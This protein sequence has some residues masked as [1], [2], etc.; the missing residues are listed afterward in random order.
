MSGARR[1]KRL[2]SRGREVIKPMKNAIF[3]QACRE[4]LASGVMLVAVTALAACSPATSVRG[5]SA[6]AA[7]EPQ[8]A[9]PAPESS[10]GGGHGRVPTHGRSADETRE[11]SGFGRALDHIK[12][13][14]WA[15]ARAAFE[16]LAAEPTPSAE[17]FYYLGVALERLGERSRAEHMYANALAVQPA[18][19]EAAL[20][21]SALYIDEKRHGDAL[22]VTSAAFAHRVPIGLELGLNHALA[23]SATG[24]TA[25]ADEVFERVLATS[26][27]DVRALLSYAQHAEGA[28]HS[29]KA[30]QLRDRAREAAGDDAS[31]LGTVGY[32]LKLAR[33][34]PG[35]I[36]LFDRAISLSDNA[37]FRTNRAQC[38]YA[39]GDKS[40]A[41]ADV[42]AAAAADPSF[43]PAHYWL[44]T[45]LHDEGR[46]AQAVSEYATFL[47]LTSAGP[48]R[49]AALAKLE[50]AKRNQRVPPKRARATVDSSSSR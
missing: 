44:G 2:G 45:W 16:Q 14:R 28:G 38:K 17:V 34:V 30:R 33:D 21:L 13:E 12:A 25:E 9:S 22:R 24:K 18:F 4:P 46:F 42:R 19:A 29:S 35:C 49:A 48:L 15:E 32:A 7:N 5:A 50:L 6:R 10:Q 3:F 36:A 31:L 20:N 1:V 11:R 41:M 39:S 40:G 8:A 26:P 37:D 23:L 47:T 43:A 27:R